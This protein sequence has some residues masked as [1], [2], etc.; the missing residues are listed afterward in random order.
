[1]QAVTEDTV[2]TRKVANPLGAYLDAKHRGREAISTYP[3]FFRSDSH[4]DRMDAVAAIIKNFFDCNPSYTT[5]RFGRGYRKYTDIVHIFKSKD[6]AWEAYRAL[7]DA[8]TDDYRYDANCE[9]A[10]VFNSDRVMKSLITGPGWD[11]STS[12]MLFI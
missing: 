2:T 3:T 8:P 12:L 7:K 4:L 5:P 6:L 10:C 9:Q 1:M 11:I